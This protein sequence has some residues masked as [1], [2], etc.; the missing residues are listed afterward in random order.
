[1]LKVARFNLN[2]PESIFTELVPND[3]PTEVV[4]V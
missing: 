3:R 1:M 4:P 2:D